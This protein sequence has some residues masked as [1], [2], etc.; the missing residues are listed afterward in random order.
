M[1]SSNS[2]IIRHVGPQQL[3]RR[4]FLR[5]ALGGLGV[6]LA[7]PVFDIMLNQHGDALAATGDALPMRFGVFHWGGGVNH[8]TW[9]PTSTGPG[10]SLPASLQDFADLKPYVTL[11]TGLN[12]TEASPGHI[13]ARGIA[14]SSSHDL[15]VCTGSCVGTYRGQNMPEPSLDALVAEKWKGK[16][17]YDLLAVGICRKGPYAS[18]SSWNRGGSSYNRHEPSPQALF[19]RLFADGVSNPSPTPADPSMLDATVKLKKSMLDALIEDAN[20]LNQKL[21][22]NDKQRLQQHLDGLRAIE[23]A[24]QLRE[25]MPS[26]T[27]CAAPDSPTR[28]DFGDG[29]SREE[30]E[31]KSKLMSDMLAVALACDMTRVFSYEW[32]ANQSQS[33]YW[34]AN[35]SGQHHEDIT[36][37]KEQTEEHTRI[38][39]FIM[40]NFAY[41]AGKLKQTQEGAGNVLDRTLIFGTSEHANAG[42]HDWEDHPLL[43]VGKAGGKIKAGSHYRGSGDNAP[44]VMFSAV[45]AV[46]VQV[47]KLGQEGR[48]ATSGFADI[49]T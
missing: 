8:K 17:K 27:M 4:T 14:L 15:K 48:A 24:L 34:E 26:S 23:S 37:G 1:K 39:R 47:T 18:N 3:P 13:P 28:K 31:A 20:A 40:K 30:K 38:I 32:S 43:L 41:L 46:G 45:K 11:V 35:S 21:G 22:A 25:G 16:T 12:H 44:K 5:G 6:S 7:L 9:V 19:D 29:G 42:N 36:H 2:R 10:Y 49:E 33:I